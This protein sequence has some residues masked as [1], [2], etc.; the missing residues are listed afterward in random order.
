MNITAK[1]QQEIE[2]F[3]D[4]FEI[5]KKNPVCLFRFLFTKKKLQNNS[6]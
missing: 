3:D 5:A 2:F 6:I 4:F 1:V